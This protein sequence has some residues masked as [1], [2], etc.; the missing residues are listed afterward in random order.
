MNR[1]KDEIDQRIEDN[2]LYPCMMGKNFVFI[3]C[4]GK[5]QGC[6]KHSLEQYDLLAGNFD[7]GWAFLGEIRDRKA[8]PSF[9]CNKCKVSDYCEQCTV[10][11]QLEHGEAE[12]PVDFYCSIG[13]MRGNMID[14]IRE[15]K[16]N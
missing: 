10:N 7:E 13:H 2:Y 9:V 8:S 12:K 5:M 11:H 16:G 6:V 14:R 3:N 4:E 1:P 15:N